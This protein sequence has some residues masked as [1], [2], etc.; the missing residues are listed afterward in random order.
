MTKIMGVKMK[1]IIV[2]IIIVTTIVF[3]SI[4]VGF[5]KN[6]P[7]KDSVI[8]DNIID[9]YSEE[10]N[11]IASNDSAIDEESITRFDSNNGIDMA[12]FFNNVLEQDDESIVFKVMVNNHLINLEDIK[13]ADLVKLKLSDG[14]TIDQGF[15]W[16]TASGGHHIFGYLKLPR[17]YDGNNII[18]QDIDSIQ[19]EFEGVGNADKLA[20]K[21]T[22][23]VLDAYIYRHE[24]I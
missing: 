3:S 10:N 9:I 24:K 23:E 14:S 20:F 13:Y 1:K 19:L 8:E 6:K 16:E 18:G 2:L 11:E 4:W 7:L 17:V 5:N 12:V 15:E 21:W 22:K